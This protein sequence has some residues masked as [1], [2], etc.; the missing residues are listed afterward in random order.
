MV[1][2]SP[3]DNWWARLQ[4]LEAEGQF[5]RE[6]FLSGDLVGFGRIPQVPQPAPRRSLPAA[7]PSAM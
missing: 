4:V 7:S 5:P 3:N 2:A 1:A 6:V